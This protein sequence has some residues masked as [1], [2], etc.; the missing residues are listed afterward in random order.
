MVTSKLKHLLQTLRQNDRVNG[1]ASR[2]PPLNF[3]TVHYLYFITTC[4]ICSV[5]FWGS[6]HP[7][8]SVGYTDSL[9]LVISAMTE[10]GLNTVNLSQITT[11]Q[12]ALLCFLIVIGS[13]IFVS[14]STVLTRKRVFENRFKHIVSLQKEVRRTRK[15]SMSFNI[16]EHP[17][18]RDEVNGSGMPLEPVVQSNLNESVE[19]HDDDNT[20]SPNASIPLAEDQPI[21]K[22]EELSEDNPSNPESSDG[23]KYD[24]GHPAGNLE[25]PSAETDANHISFMRYGPSPSLSERRF[26]TFTGVGASPNA[27]GYK[28][29]YSTSIYTRATQKEQDQTPAMSDRGVLDHGNYPNYLTRTTTGRNGQVF[30]LT[31]EQREHLGGVEYRAITLLSWIVPVYF[32]LWQFLGCLGLGAYIA[33]NKAKV[34][35][36]NGINPW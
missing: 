32:V 3:I 14:I 19:S 27:T 22:P 7:T 21:A 31:R 23:L 28:S 5:I 29:P 34:S 25:I 30:G 16:A 20:L 4:L 12:Q 11:F 17:P 33:H 26:L 10:A 36:D 1:V 6:S 35:E 24:S 18:A 8:K 13:S 9:F 15:R 2:L